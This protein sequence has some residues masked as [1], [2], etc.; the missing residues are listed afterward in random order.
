MNDALRTWWSTGLTVA[1]AALYG[2]LGLA[3][4]GVDRVLGL[5]G[6]LLVVAAV[7]AAGRSRA[8]AVALLVSGA[9][10]LAVV[11]WW[12]IAAPLVGL[13]ILVLGWTAVRT[14]SAPTPPPNP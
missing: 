3:A 2:W 5:S 6:V 13:L 1:L 14:R 8:L 12:S 9:A 11:A 10:P 4:H 7:S